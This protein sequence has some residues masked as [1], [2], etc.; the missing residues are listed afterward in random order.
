MQRISKEILA[1]CRALLEDG[2]ADRVMGWENG[3]FYYDVTPA[4][5][6]KET[7]DNMIYDDFCASNQSK[8]FILESKKEGKIIA[9]LKPCDTYSFNQ[10]LKENRINRENVYVLGIPCD[11]KIDVQKQLCLASRVLPV[12]N[13]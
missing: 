9:L 1:K 10:L 6:T 11:G 12:L 7:L 3:E 13:R 5:F 2:T 4:V 8:Y